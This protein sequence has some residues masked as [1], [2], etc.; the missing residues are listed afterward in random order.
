MI[1]GEN[2]V[3]GQEGRI[4]EGIV[5]LMNHSPTTPQYGVVKIFRDT[6]S[7]SIAQLGILH[8]TVPISIRYEPR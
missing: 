7:C 4:V 5:K 6:P 3:D 1:G 2:I 8:L